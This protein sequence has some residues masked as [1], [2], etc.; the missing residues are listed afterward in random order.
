MP[1]SVTTALTQKFQRGL[2][3]EA[4]GLNFPDDAVTD[5]V[6]VKFDP[7]GF[8]ERR[9]GIDLEG[10]AEAL[11]YVDTD[12]VIKEFV[13]TA[14]ANAGELTFLV[15]QKGPEVRFY[16]VA[17]DSQVSPNIMVPA[18]N[19]QSYKAPGAP[20]INMVPCSFA[21][22]QGYLYI[23]HPYCDPVIVRYISA[24]NSF[25]ISK[26]NIQVRDFDGVDDGLKVEE[27]PSS[28][29]KEHNYNLLNQ[30]WDTK[31]RVGTVTNELG[32]NSTG[33]VTPVCK[34]LWTAVPS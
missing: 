18:V 22:G 21:S 13:W 33:N 19:L 29:S 7:V 9:L 15:L 10:S 14:I 2:V 12:G 20:D 6:N 8:V 11:S 31:V 28:L 34:L 27:N 16:K 25:Q 32:N 30:G 4:T 23:A 5:S 3:T 1:R 24:T 26:I 17:S